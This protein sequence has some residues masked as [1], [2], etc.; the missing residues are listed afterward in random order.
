MVKKFRE[1]ENYWDNYYKTHKRHRNPSRFAKFCLKYLKPKS[2]IMDIGCGDG[3]DSY[4]FYK[5][6][7]KVYG[8]DNAEIVERLENKKNLRFIRC[9]LESIN[10]KFSCN[11][12]NVYCRFILHCIDESIQKTLF[13]W[14]KY[15]KGILCIETRSVNDKLYD[16]GKKVGEDAFITNHYRRFLRKEDLEK[17]LKKNGFKIIFSKED[18]NFAPYKNENPSIIRIIAKC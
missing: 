16:K 8:I 5:K 18:I 14:I 3:R 12:D 2:S 10:K 15:I 9:N 4:F 13:N 17:I 1:I 11:V 7:F 6:G